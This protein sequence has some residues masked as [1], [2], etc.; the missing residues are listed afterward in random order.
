MIISTDF[1]VA[2][3]CIACGAFDFISINLFG[4]LKQKYIK[5]CCRCGQ[6]HAEFKYFDDKI[7]VSVPCIACGTTHEYIIN[8]QEIRRKKIIKFVCKNTGVEHCF[9]G[10]DYVVRQCVDSLEREM[11]SMMDTLGYES[12]FANSQVMLETINRIHDLAERRRLICQCGCREVGIHLHYKGVFLKCSKCFCY[13]YIPAASNLDLKITL[14]K[15]TIILNDKKAKI[16]A[17]I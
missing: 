3:K 9:V 16:S 5:E 2:Y 12:F 1:T 14:S 10:N 17:P 6:A 7:S 11:D 13:K 8:I 4:L 15:K